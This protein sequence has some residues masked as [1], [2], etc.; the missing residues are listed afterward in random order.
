M[1]QAVATGASNA[2]VGVQLHVAASTVKKYLDNTYAKLGVFGRIRAAA[3]ML[4]ML[5]HH[6]L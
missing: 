2:E 6:K 4:E 5:G 1:L 3:V